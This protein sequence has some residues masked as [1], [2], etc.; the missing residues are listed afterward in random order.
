MQQL[1]D[2]MSEAVYLSLKQAVETGKWPDG[3]EL[4]AE[5]RETCGAATM[6]YQSKHRVDGEHMT[7]DE[8]GQLIMKSK[9]QLR[10]LFREDE[11]TRVRLN[12]E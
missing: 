2:N 11:I 12:E 9:S 6:Y 1:L 4:T 10:G 8:D 3:T 5:Q 7:L